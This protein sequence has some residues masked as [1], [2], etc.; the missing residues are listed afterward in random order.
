[1]S[2]TEIENGTIKKILRRHVRGL[3]L[4]IIN[5]M[6][7]IDPGLVLNE[8]DWTRKDRAGNP[9]GGELALSLVVYLKMPE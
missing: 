3:Q 8:D 9:G 5:K 4:E 6:R 7:E 1:M 2:Q